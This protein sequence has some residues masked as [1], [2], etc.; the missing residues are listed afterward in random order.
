MFQLICQA[1]EK[2]KQSKRAGKNGL[3]KTCQKFYKDAIELEGVKQTQ[4]KNLIEMP[5]YKKTTEFHPSSYPGS[6][7]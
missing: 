1:R 2:G 3:K 5:K 7:A 6:L 4:N